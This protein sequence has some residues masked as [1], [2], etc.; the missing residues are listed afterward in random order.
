MTPCDCSSYPFTPP[1]FKHGPRPG[2]PLNR[3]VSV[4]N[5]DD[6]DDVRSQRAEACAVPAVSLFWIRR[7]A[8]LLCKQP[9]VFLHRAKG[10]RS[11]AAEL[12]SRVE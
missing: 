5:E 7:V 12:M 3:L 4:T 8:P 9:T 2:R 6:R 1:V 10:G 11:L